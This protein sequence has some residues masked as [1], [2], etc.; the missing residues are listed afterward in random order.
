LYPSTFNRDPTNPTTPG[1]GDGGAGGGGGGGGRPTPPLITNFPPD[2]DLRKA[3]YGVDYNPAK[4]LMP[5]CGAD[6]QSIINDVNLMSQI[7]NRIRLYGMDCGQADLTFQA[8]K[9]LK[10][11]MQVVLTI[12][13]D[14]NST[15]YQRQRDTL[16][17]VLDVYGTDMLTGVS[18]GNE[19]LFRKDMDLTTLGGLMTVSVRPLAC[20]IYLLISGMFDQLLTSCLFLNTFFYFY[21]TP[22]LHTCTNVVCP[23]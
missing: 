3:F 19:V 22:Q 15:T 5:W 16:F 1:G 21:F 14:N 7:T 6:L 20:N 2:P 17:Q 23:L 4:T 8:I 9:L 10:V 11:P 12:W 13:V 18:V